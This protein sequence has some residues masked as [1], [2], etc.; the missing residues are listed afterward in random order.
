MW[1]KVAPPPWTRDP[2]RLKSI[3]LFA[4]VPDDELAE[5]ATFAQEVTVE[6]GRELVREGDYSYEFM[7]IEDGSAEVTRD[8]EHVAELGAGDFSARS[9]YSS[10]TL[11]NA[12]VTATSPTR[13]VTL[14]GW[15]LKRTRAKRARGDRARPGHTRGTPARGLSAM[16]ARIVLFGAT[17]YTGRL[18]AE[19]MVERGLRPVL[20]ARGR[21]GSPDGGGSA[22]LGRRLESA[23]RGR[24]PIRRP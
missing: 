20:A 1:G 19:A 7:V 13:V 12:T 18:T 10:A 16:A 23:R 6:A 21:E 14:T 11:R 8:G 5:I 2:G 9:G 3:P 17:G 22:E 24:R 4:D 15:D